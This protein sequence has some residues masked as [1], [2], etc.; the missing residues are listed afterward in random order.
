MLREFS[1][2]LFAC[3]IA[4]HVPSPECYWA[5]IQWTPSSPMC[6]VRLPKPN[7]YFPLSAMLSQKKTH[8]YPLKPVTQVGFDFDGTRFLVVSNTWISRIYS[9]AL[10]HRY[11]KN[12]W[13]LVPRKFRFHCTQLKHNWIII[14][15]AMRH[16]VQ[17]WRSPT[18]SIALS[19]DIR[20]SF[21]ST[22]RLR[23]NTCPV[24]P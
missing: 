7:I 23:L 10:P 14:R 12:C 9:I 1:N 22:K 2:T 5:D 17:A 24:L 16:R 18:E 11:G 21:T 19:L 3:Y 8:I 4:E 15:G 13:G 6:L 20:V